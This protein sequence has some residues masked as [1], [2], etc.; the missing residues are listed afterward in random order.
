MVVMKRIVFIGVLIACSFGNS[1]SQ[2]DYIARANALLQAKDFNKAKA[3]I[4]SCVKDSKYGNDA[5]AWYLRG[6]IYKA[7]YQNKEKT[8]VESPA[9]ITAL[10]SFK[11]SMKLDN[12]AENVSE[13]KKNIKFLATSIYN[14]VIKGLD[15]INYNVAIRNFDKF[16]MYYALAD[17][18]EADLKTD[19]VTY[20][21]ALASVFE[22]FFEKS[23][24]HE[25]KVKY[26]NL[27]VQQ[28]SE[29]LAEAPTNATAKLN[30]AT[31]I[32]RAADFQI[33]EKEKQFKQELDVKSTTINK[34]DKDNQLK[35]SEIQTKESV[36]KTKEEEIKEKVMESNA[37][38]QVIGLLKEEKDLKDEQI[39][40]QTIIRNILIGGVLI[41]LL[42][43]VVIFRQRNRISKEKHR[44]DELLLNILP[45]EVA[46]ELKKTGTAK[47]KHY[48]HV[49]VL[50]TDF[51]G[52]T[53]ISEKLSPQELVEEIHACFT[54]FDAIIER[55]GMEKIKT[56]GDAY[57]AVCGMPNEDSDHAKKT[58]TAS[59]EI[60]DYINKRINEGGKF[61]IRIG[62]NSGPV[63]A[64]IVGVKKFA[65]DIWGDA[66]NTAA[67]MEQTSV[68][69]KVNISGATY[70]LIKD[71]FNCTYRGKVD[72]KNKG[73]IDMYFVD[74]KI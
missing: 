72:A 13:N 60:M 71:N 37:K 55:N 54:A 45:E 15:T 49:S 8:V 14:D 43:S 20:K 5:Q 25:M 30:R 24:S 29:I 1:F 16:K 9:R 41:L 67:R 50:F 35:Q 39:H 62:I 70:E 7:I 38:T 63:V 11:K 28:Y 65:Y 58:V 12:S 52:F 42:F 34:L 44:S 40:Q 3:C 47:A 22:K 26:Y 48:N 57:L 51:V 2:T 73:E 64:G 21:L 18:S 23:P 56:I 6:F 33:G 32:A 31:L 74:G 46:N 53:I 59:L 27:A 36:I 10:E 69:G 66:V 61:K 19:D 4:D 68:H 17:A